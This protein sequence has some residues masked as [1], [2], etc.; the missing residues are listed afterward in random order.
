MNFSRI[1]EKLIQTVWVGALWSVGYIAAPALFAHLDPATAGRVAG[2]LFTVVAW[3][4][5]VCGVSLMLAMRG[6]TRSGGEAR[7]RNRLIP[8]MMTLVGS[9]EWI[10]RP[11]MEAA[12]L[13]DGTPGAGFGMWHGVSALLY[14]AASLLAI[15]LVAAPGRD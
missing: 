12:R 14:L 1:G 10:V 8:L 15:L 6:T 5:M 3:L 11:L 7:L 4:S 9:S 2:E 13:P